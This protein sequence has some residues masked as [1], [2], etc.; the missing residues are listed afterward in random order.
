M[1]KTRHLL[2]NTKYISRKSYYFSKFVWYLKQKR[3]KTS[4]NLSQDENTN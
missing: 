3:I 2:D 1:K 4:K